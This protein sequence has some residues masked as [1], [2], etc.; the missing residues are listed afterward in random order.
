MFEVKLVWWLC[1]LGLIIVKILLRMVFWFLIVDFFINFFLIIFV[2]LIVFIIGVIFVEVISFILLVILNLLFL[3]DCFLINFFCFSGIVLLLGL[4][5]LFCCV[6]VFILYVL[7]FLWVSFKFER[8]VDKFIFICLE[9]GLGF[10]LS[11]WFF[12]III[13]LL[14]IIEGVI[15]ECFLLFLFLYCRV[16]LSCLVILVL[17]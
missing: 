12:S 16:F 1:F 17:R 2:V 7:F 15:D 14:F 5:L 10:V 13:D 9:V 8:E 4:C 3:V 11:L 6:G